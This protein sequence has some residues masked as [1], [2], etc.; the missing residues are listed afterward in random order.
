MAERA[1]GGVELLVMRHAKSA[2]DTGDVDFDRPLADRGRRAGAAMAE[3][4]ADH[5]L[6]PDYVISSAA[7]RAEST[8]RFVIDA[9]AVTRE[10][11]E[12]RS[13]LY[14]CS[15]QAWV[16]ELRT[17]DASH[18]R[19]IL[20][21]GHNPTFDDLVLGLSATPPPLSAS[22]K[23]M[24]TAAVAHLRFNHD[25]PQLGTKPGELV[26]LRRPREL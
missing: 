2:W 26:Q 22:G 7:A 23:L 20:I 10:R 13:D 6:G 4:I 16:D 15:A 5:D 17:H 19:R 12:M 3:L 24:T 8:A 9:C 21:V 25:W 1:D 11:W 18:A 14:G